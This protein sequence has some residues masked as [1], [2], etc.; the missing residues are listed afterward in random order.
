MR[1]RWVIAAI[2]LGFILVLF[3]L[4]VEGFIGSS[5]A[6]VAREHSFVLP[7]SAKHIHCGG[8]VAISTLGDFDASVSFDI[9]LSDLPSV[10]TQFTLDS[11]TETPAFLSTRMS[12]PSHFGALREA[13][14]GMSR[15]T[16]AVHLQVF[17][18]VDERVGV[19][20][21]TIWN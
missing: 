14:F 18:L 2:A 16:N 15:K 19:C 5:V 7:A 6:R 4:Y 17:D 3:G 8:P 11:A 21:L 13:R 1:K 10:L 20:V 12:V 9:T